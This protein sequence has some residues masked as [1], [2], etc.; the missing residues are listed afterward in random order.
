MLRPDLSPQH[1]IKLVVSRVPSS[2]KQSS[3]VAITKYLDLVSSRHR[4]IHS[5]RPNFIAKY[6][7]QSEKRW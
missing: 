3:N 7:H 2:S 1:L 4:R 5:L 6:K